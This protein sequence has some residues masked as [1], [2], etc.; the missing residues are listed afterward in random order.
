ELP[1][2]D[3]LPA[4]FVAVL[5]LPAGAGIGIVDATLEFAGLAEL[6]RSVGDLRLGHVAVAAGSGELQH[7]RREIARV[8]LRAVTRALG[9]I[10]DRASRHHAVAVEAGFALDL[11]AELIEIVPVARREEIAPR[12][13]Q[14]ELEIVDR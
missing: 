6:A 11:K 7:Q 14:R 5:L 4:R 10:S 3:V 2:V 1:L 12:V 8:A 13:H 9:E